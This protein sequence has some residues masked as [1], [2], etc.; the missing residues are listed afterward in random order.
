ML[1]NE[2][3]KLKYYLMQNQQSSHINLEGS[4]TK[5]TN[6]VVIFYFSHNLRGSTAEYNEGEF[7]MFKCVL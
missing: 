3:I 5:I 2:I 4:I 7:V 6:L 1:I